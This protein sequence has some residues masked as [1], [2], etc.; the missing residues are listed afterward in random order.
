M[1]LFIS[2]KD[3]IVLKRMDDILSSL[4][5]SSKNIRRKRHLGT[6]SHEIETQRTHA[7]IDKIVLDNSHKESLAYLYDRMDDGVAFFFF[8]TGTKPNLF[9]KYSA[10]GQSLC[11]M[12]N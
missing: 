7:G 4:G 2:P 9:R 6:P 1:P 12:R 3:S 8:S 5:R 11:A 10:C